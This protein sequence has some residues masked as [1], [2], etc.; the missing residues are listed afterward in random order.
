MRKWASVWFRT[1][2][3]HPLKPRER[4]RITRNT[5]PQLRTKMYYWEWANM[6][7]HE[8]KVLFALDVLFFIIMGAN[9]LL[10]IAIILR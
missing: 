3:A 8:N 10:F 6:V 4:A 9:A 7:R 2:T 1:Y 5:M